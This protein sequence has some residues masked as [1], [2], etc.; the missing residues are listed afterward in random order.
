MS[1]VSWWSG[2]DSYD[3]FYSHDAPRTAPPA[4]P[5]RVHEF[6]GISY[7]AP[8][9]PRD[10]PWLF[11]NSFGLTA[12][13]LDYQPPLP[14]SSTEPRLDASMLMRSLADCASINTLSQRVLSAD[15]APF[16]PFQLVALMPGSCGVCLTWDTRS[17]DK[18]Q[19]FSNA[20]FRTNSQ[21]EPLIAQ[22]RHRQFCEL[23]DTTPQLTPE[24]LL[25]LHQ[26]HDPDAP[27]ASICASGEASQTAC[28]CHV[29]ADTEQICLRYYPKSF[30]EHRFDAPIE[31]ML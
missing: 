15:L 22:Y 3:L 21:T 24:A 23:L 8:V 5:P 28:I 20:Q 18:S 1:T 9:D 16:E 13:L 6:A 10:G 2:T 25:R 17:I 12:G 26:R 7:L 27:E 4:M 30:D 29:T 31:L 11:V 14:K 19:N